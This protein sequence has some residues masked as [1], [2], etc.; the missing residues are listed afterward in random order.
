MAV[1]LSALRTSRTL[2][3]RNII[4]LLLVL[5]KPQG[6]V[7][8]EESG[9]LKKIIQHV[10]SR[11]RDLSDCSSVLTNRIP[12]AGLFIKIPASSDI[13]PC[14]A[15]FQSHLLSTT[16]GRR[17][18]ISVRNVD[19]FLRNYVAPN[20]GQ[21]ARSFPFIKLTICRVRGSHGRDYEERRLLGCGACGFIIDGRFGKNVASIFRVEEMA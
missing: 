4:F 16:K 8:L 14:V 7:W 18:R 13:P 11:S 5:S 19:A 2:L 17:V 3:P 9:K 12:R 20:L 6:L 10:G 21:S 15:T 1:R